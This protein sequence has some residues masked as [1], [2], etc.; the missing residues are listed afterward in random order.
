MTKMTGLRDVIA[1]SST[2]ENRALNLEA[3]RAL[4]ETLVMLKEKNDGRLIP[5]SSTL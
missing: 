1:S 2:E 3:F 5:V 4:Q